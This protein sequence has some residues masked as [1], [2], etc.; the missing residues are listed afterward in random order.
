MS[1]IVQIYVLAVLAELTSAHTKPLEKTSEFKSCIQGSPSCCLQY[2]S[3]GSALIQ[4]SFSLCLGLGKSSGGGPHPP[5]QLLS[6]QHTSQLLTSQT[7][8][9]CCHMLV[10]ALHFMSLQVLLQASNSL[11]NGQG[12]FFSLQPPCM[13]GV[14]RSKFLCASARQLCWL[15][16]PHPLHCPRFPTSIGQPSRVWGRNLWLNTEWPSVSSQH[17]SRLTGL[18]AG[19]FLSGAT[20]NWC[21]YTASSFNATLMAVSPGMSAL[22][23]TVSPG[24]SC[25]SAATV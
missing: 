3:S 18:L 20:L 16:M 2:Q 9:G 14:L 15:Q 4:T 1:W 7:S 12:I 19:L 5:H 11:T 23:C 24:L 8:S 6:V 22:H 10:K 13:R 17:D 25:F 21:V